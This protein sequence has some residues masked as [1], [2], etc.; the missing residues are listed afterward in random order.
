MIYEPNICPFRYG[1]GVFGDRWSLL[2]IRDMM[3]RGFRRF[4]DFMDSGEGI[5]SNVLS[6]RLSRLES[7]NVISRKKDPEDGRQILYELTDQGKDLAPVMLTIIG[8]AEKYDPES[9]ISHEWAERIRTDL[10]EV[11]N[12]VLAEMKT[13]GAGG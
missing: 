10:F 1:L 13:S 2:I 8:W 7:Q 3:F 6:D 5:S 4:H 12:E 11:Q 9:N